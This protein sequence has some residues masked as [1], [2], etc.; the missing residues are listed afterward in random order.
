[1]GTCWNC[2]TQITLKNEEVKCDNCKKVIN[3]CCNYCKEWFSLYDESSN[4][5][6]KECKVCGYFICPKCGTCSQ[7]C[8][9]EIWQNEITKILSPEINYQ[10]TPKL[11]LKINRILDFIESIKINHEQI[12]CPNRKVSIT[13][14][15]NRIKS[16]FVRILG[17]KCRDKKDL[18]KFKERFE[19]ISNVN[20]GTQLTINQ[21][22]EEGS[23]GQEYRDVFNLCVCLGKL[24]KQIARKTIDGEEIEFECW[25]RV[26]EGPC[27]LFDAKEL[28]KKKCP[29][30]KE[31]YDIEKEYCINEKCIYKKG[32]LTGQNRKLKLSIS[33]KDICQLNRGGFKK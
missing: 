27:Q 22:R 30:C 11:Q 3:Y 15:K 4:L 7:N 10:N 21:I 33:N 16:C 31:K 23:Y 19:E 20:L 8:L 24:K 28:M 32:K 17:Y 1:M 13:Y 14:A 6:I 25:R 12:T 2:G 9:K 29:K 5:K 26:E 18:D